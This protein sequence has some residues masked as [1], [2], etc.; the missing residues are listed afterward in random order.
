MVAV[1]KSVYMVL[2]FAFSIE[3]ELTSESLR[4]T[5]NALSVGLRPENLSQS[6]HQ[7]EGE[8]SP[9]STIDSVAESIDHI[10]TTRCVRK[11]IARHIPGTRKSSAECAREQERL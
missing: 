3:N 11:D 8:R 6:Q 1:C 7:G 5:P 2:R 4:W 9:M 10:Y